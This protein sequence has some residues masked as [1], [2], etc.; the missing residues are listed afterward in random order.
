[1]NVGNE[2][3]VFYVV[4]LPGVVFRKLDAIYAM[5]EKTGFKKIVSVERFPEGR[6]VIYLHIPLQ[7]DAAFE[8]VQ[9]VVLR[10]YGCLPEANTVPHI[11]QFDPY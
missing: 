1:M 9:E 8:I 2:P 7:D 11:T 6:L 4:S 3:E 5:L 10:I